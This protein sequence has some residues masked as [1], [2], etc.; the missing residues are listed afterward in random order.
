[1]ATGSKSFTG[2]FVLPAELRA[3]LELQEGNQTP[4]GQ[5]SEA[6]K[7]RSDGLKPLP[8]REHR[9][10]DAENLEFGVEDL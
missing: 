3:P 6:A 8:E 5:K 1:M 7:N 2:I 4:A 9:R 10:V